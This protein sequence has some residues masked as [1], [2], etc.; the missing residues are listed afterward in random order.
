VKALWNVLEDTGAVD[1]F[2]AALLGLGHLI[3]GIFTDSQKEAEQGAE[4][5]LTGIWNMISGV[6]GRI[7][8]AVGDMF[9][10]MWTEATEGAAEGLSRLG[11]E[12]WNWVTGIVDSVKAFI[13]QK[14]TG[15]FDSLPVPDFLKDALGLAGEETQ[16]AGATVQDGMGRAAG[17]V[18][19]G[20]N[21]AWQ[22]TAGFA[23]QTFQGAASTIQSIFGGIVA[24]IETQVG[25][26]V[27]GAQ[28]MLGGG[29]MVPAAAGVRA[30]NAGRGGGV[31]VNQS[32]RIN[33]DARGG[34]PAKVQQGVQR[35]LDPNRTAR[36]AAS[37]TVQKG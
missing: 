29:A 11:S 15:L 37:G 20:F 24:G 12:I 31:T 4:Q 34:D 32:N 6:L 21:G 3:H 13:T 7:L 19:E 36:A 25:T 9:S 22:A 17:A 10:D 35:G 23:I 18:K 28:R 30:Q 16:K 33:V 27:A 2:K 26:L 1:G 8:G 5:M 14:L